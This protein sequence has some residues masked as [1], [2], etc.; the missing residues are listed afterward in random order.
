MNLIDIGHKHLIYSRGHVPLLSP[1]SIR[2]HWSQSGDNSF[3]FRLVYNLIIPLICAVEIIN[4]S[5]TTA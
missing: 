4:L 5:K 2:A 1:F 3:Y